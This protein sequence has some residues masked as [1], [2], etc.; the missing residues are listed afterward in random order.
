MLGEVVFGAPA[1]IEAE[2]VSVTVRS[3]LIGEQRIE[4]NKKLSAR[5]FDDGTKADT[6]GFA[7]CGLLISALEGQG[8][9]VTLRA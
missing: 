2:T 4:R 3:D 7:I 9:A 1:I 6:I 8:D 5:K